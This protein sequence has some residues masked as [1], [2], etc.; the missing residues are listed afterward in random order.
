MNAPTLLSELI[1]LR[2]DL[3][4]RYDG[5]P[6]SPTRWMGSGLNALNHLID[7]GYSIEYDARNLLAKIPIYPHGP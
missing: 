3:A 7:G 5:A 1:S 4:D 6:D 2:D